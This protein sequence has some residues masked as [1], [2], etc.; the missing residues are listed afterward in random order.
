ME[1]IGNVIQGS[2]TKDETGFGQSHQPSQPC[3]V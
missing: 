3:F 2:K 1:V